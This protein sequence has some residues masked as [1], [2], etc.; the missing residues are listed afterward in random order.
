MQAIARFQL[1]YHNSKPLPTKTLLVGLKAAFILAALLPSACQIGPVEL[2][3]VRS[4]AAT[5]EANPAQLIAAETPA[6]TNSIAPKTILTAASRTQ[7]SSDTATPPAGLVLLTPT[8]QAY[9]YQAQSGDTLAAVAA[10]F[11]VRPEDITSPAPLPADRLLNPGQLLFI[12]RRSQELP[13]GLRLLPDSEVVFSPSA[14]G[15]EV[16]AYVN[17]AGGYFSSHYEYL[18]STGWTSGAEILGRI[19]LENSINPRL[20]LSL[21][22]Y[23]CG[24]VLGDLGE[25]FDPDYL[26]GVA[27]ANKRGLYR[28]LGWAIN[29]LSLGYYN[30]RSGLLTELYLADGQI[31]HLP[32]DWNAGSA[33]LGYLFAQLYDSQGWQEA[34]DPASGLPALHQNMFGDAWLRAQSVEPLLPAGL[35]QPVFILP[36]LPGQVWSYTSGPHKAWETEGALAALDFA[37]PS[38]ESGCAPSD[39]WVLA[40]ADGLVA[41]AEHGAVVLDLDGDGYEQT[42]WAVLYMHIAQRDQAA[43]GVYLRTGELVGH[44]SCEGGRASGTHLHIARKYN[45][46]WIPAAGPL[47]FNLDGWVAQAGYKPYEGTLTRAGQT[48]VANPYSS[49]STFIMRWIEDTPPSNENHRPNSEGV[50]DD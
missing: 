34:L 18:R 48:I 30:W 41:R 5:Y 23:R 50:K 14:A 33:A 45:G 15:F 6:D 22:E 37:P 7:V 4:E 28:Q 20:L 29:Q 44:P 27:D 8:P 36:F 1:T 21:L 35:T 40:V 9:Q 16:A 12:A 24:C 26:L 17:E 31:S 10:R 11:R 25:G 19:A 47:P 42:G 2:E 32:P 13:S 39:A 38:T 3:E 46:E 49:A 43:S